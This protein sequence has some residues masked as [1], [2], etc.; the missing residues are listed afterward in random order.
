MGL[1][2]IYDWTRDDVAFAALRRWIEAGNDADLLKMMGYDPEVPVA[3]R[4]CATARACS[5]ASAVTRA[6]S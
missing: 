1:R 3:P 4:S 2:A 6:S 5:C